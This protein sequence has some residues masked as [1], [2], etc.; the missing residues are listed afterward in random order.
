M[1]NSR[2]KGSAYERE[3]AQEL[4][5][6]TGI[7]LK[8]D[9]DQ[10][11]ATDRGDLV[12]DDPD[13]PL[14]IECKRRASGGFQAAWWQQASRAAVA[15]NKRAAVIYRFD[16]QPTRVRVQLRTAMELISGGKWSAPDQHLIDIDLDGLAYLIREGVN[17]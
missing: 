13:F 12:C 9:L 17:A 2:N 7:N 6:L 4:Y 16:R 5:R 11:R 10:Y 15:Q 3:I 1:T 14:I 8:R